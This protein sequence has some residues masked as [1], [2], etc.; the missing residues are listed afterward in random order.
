MAD[1]KYFPADRN[2]SPTMLYLQAQYLTG[3]TP[4]ELANMYI[5]FHDRIS[6]E[7]VAIKKRQAEEKNKAHH[8]N[9]IM[10]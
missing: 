2:D 3:K 10:Y 1:A 5:Q 8:Y 6:A 4:E 7:F 9:P